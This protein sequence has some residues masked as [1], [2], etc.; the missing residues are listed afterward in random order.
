MNLVH[1]TALTK[2]TYGFGDYVEQ[3]GDDDVSVMIRVIPEHA[4]QLAWVALFRGSSVSG[5]A[6]L[7]NK[8]RSD[9]CSTLPRVAFC[10]CASLTC[11]CMALCITTVASS[12]RHPTTYSLCMQVPYPCLCWCTIPCYLNFLLPAPFLL[13]A[14]TQGTIHHYSFRSCDKVPRNLRSGVAPPTL[15]MLLCG[16]DFEAEAAAHA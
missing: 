10:A 1:L 6:R 15:H 12:D 3:D 16:P 11:S 7:Q 14:Q 4:R 13:C 9:I 5:R 8:L 2:L